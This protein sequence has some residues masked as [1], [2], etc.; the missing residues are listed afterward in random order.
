MCKESN[1]SIKSFLNY[2]PVKFLPKMQVAVREISNKHTMIKA[3]ILFDFL[4]AGPLEWFLE[5]IFVR[6][7]IQFIIF[8]KKI[9]IRIGNSKKITN[10][11]QE[12]EYNNLLT[13]IKGKNEIDTKE[14]F[15]ITRSYWLNK[16]NLNSIKFL[17]QTVKFLVWPKKIGVFEFKEDEHF[18]KAFTSCIGIAS[19]ERAMHIEV[20]LYVTVC[21]K[22]SGESH[23]EISSSY[24]KRTKE[25]I[26][27]NANCLLENIYGLEN[28][29]KDIDEGQ[30]IMPTADFLK[31]ANQT[32]AF[33]FITSIDYSERIERI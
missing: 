19:N 10:S 11:I 27:F 21:I 9:S 7:K 12:K 33:G 25:I 6:E 24:N 23:M 16:I 20:L 18:F 8:Q 32:G 5:D 3:T 31:I 17:G 14:I 4:V 30:L 13:L 2:M 1:T 28:K 22:Y 29:F 26:F 15:K